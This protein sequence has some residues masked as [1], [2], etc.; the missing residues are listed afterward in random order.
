[1]ASVAGIEIFDESGQL[2]PRRRSLRGNKGI[3][4]QDISNV[5]QLGKVC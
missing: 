3:P 4:L 1:M 2:A 5:N